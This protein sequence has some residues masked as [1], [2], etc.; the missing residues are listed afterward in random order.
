[1]NIHPGNNILR[2][3][4]QS[5][6]S[7]T[8]IGKVSSHQVSGSDGTSTSIETNSVESLTSLLEAG[9]EVRESLVEEIKLK[10]QAGEEDVFMLFLEGQPIGEPVVQYGPFVMNSQQ[11]IQEAF[12]DYQRTEFG[13]WPW[14]EKE[15]SHGAE[16]GRFAK[17]ADG[18]V[19]RP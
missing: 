11:E 7:Q 18:T 3:H 16:A 13:G 2:P 14:P 8:K 1:M 17:H 15:Q 5:Q 10:I 4:V 6:N 19:E 12:M 9:A